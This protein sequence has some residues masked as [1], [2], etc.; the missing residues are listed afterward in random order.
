M[1][2]F[3][4]SFSLFALCMTL[5]GSATAGPAPSTPPAEVEARWAVFS[6]NIVDALESDHEGLQQGALRMI[7]Q[8]G[9]QIDAQEAVFDVVRL[10]RDH[11]DENVRRMAVVALGTM[12][13]PWVMDFLER[14]LNYERSPVIRK[15]IRAALS[16]ENS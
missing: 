14:S 4:I 10:Y 6:R 16:S 8:Y 1:K 11:E 13:D 15:Q 5:V 3:S 2:R 12:Q 7:I 9:T